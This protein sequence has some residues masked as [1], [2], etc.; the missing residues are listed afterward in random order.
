MK[1]WRLY[2][3]Y[4]WIVVKILGSLFYATSLPGRTK[5][6]HLMSCYAP[7]RHLCER[8][9]STKLAITESAGKVHVTT[10]WGNEEIAFEALAH[11]STTELTYK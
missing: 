9:S 5:G 4:Q 8:G 1:K 7:Y 10:F 11:P 6:D 2:K 3:G